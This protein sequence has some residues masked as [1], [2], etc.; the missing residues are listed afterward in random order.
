MKFGLIITEAG[1]HC[2]N[3]CLLNGREGW[4]Q[5]GSDRREGEKGRDERIQGEEAK[6]VE[7]KK[8]KGKKLWLDWDHKRNW[9]YWGWKSNLD[10]MWRAMNII[11][12]FWCVGNKKPMNISEQG[13]FKFKAMCYKKL[14]GPCSTRGTGVRRPRNQL[15]CIKTFGIMI[16]GKEIKN[17]KEGDVLHRKK[18]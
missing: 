9:A 14:N 6:E 18:N 15:Y 1:D 8:G 13:C 10:C 12:L 2:W 11:L 4:K 5:R 17:T 3:L 7:G 16:N